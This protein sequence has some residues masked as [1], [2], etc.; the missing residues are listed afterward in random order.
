MLVKIEGCE[1][2]RKI[3]ATVLG[4]GDLV[5][6]MKRRTYIDALTVTDVLDDGGES[7]NMA[8][9]RRIPLEDTLNSFP[10]S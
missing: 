9:K 4:K 1:H 8:R 5:P 3:G 10:M 6:E 2:F 7:V